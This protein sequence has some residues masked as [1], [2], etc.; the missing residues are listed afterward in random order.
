MH[1][2]YFQGIINAQIAPIPFLQFNGT[3]VNLLASKTPVALNFT[4]GPVNYFVRIN[5]DILS[6][7]KNVGTTAWLYWDIDLVTAKLTYN[8]TTHA[9]LFGETFPSTPLK[10]QHFFN[11]KINKMYVWNGQ[12]WIE[13][14]R[15]FAGRVTNDLIIPEALSS[16]VNKNIPCISGEILFDF[17]QRPIRVFDNDGTFHLLTDTAVDNFYHTAKENFQFGKIKLNSIANVDL[18][19]YRCVR[20]NDDKKIIAA[21][22]LDLNPASAIISRNASTGEVVEII[23]RGFLRNINWLWKYEPNTPLF[24]GVNG[25]LSPV[26]PTTGS[27]QYVGYIVNPSTIY[28]NFDRQILINPVDVSPTPSR[29][30]SQTPTATITPTHT[31]TPTPTPTTTHTAPVTPTPTRT[32][33]QTPTNTVTPTRTV[34]PTPTPTVTPTGS[35]PLASITPTPSLTA[36]VTPTAAATVTPTPTLSLTPTNT[37]TPTMTA[38]VTPTISQTPSVT[39][40]IS[41]TPTLSLT[42]TQTIT[43]TMT[44]SVSPTVTPSVTATITPTPTPSAGG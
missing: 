9:P 40:T 27:I 28:I 32:P 5:S 1:L 18:L 20:W 34:T 4:H 29:T 10:D 19:E 13:V 35:P 17:Q 26:V 15:L 37:I 22:Y 38:S 39:P 23:T 36:S 24:V 11:I 21:S 42:P 3:D 6:A 25:E 16:Q 8:F 12:F 7:W 33:S 44:P 2:N 30:P 41:F 31:S 14:V 43:P